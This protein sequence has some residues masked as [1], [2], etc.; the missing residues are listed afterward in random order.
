MKLTSIIH[1]LYAAFGRGD[2]PAI[3]QRLHPEVLWAANVDYT[4]PAA[5]RVPCYEAGHG[6]DFVA[7]YFGLFTRNY[8]VRDFQIAGVMEGANEAAARLLV[9]LAIRP[10]GKTVR[11]EVIHHYL[12]DD[13]GFI[14]RF[15]DIE[16][17][18]GFANAWSAE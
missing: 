6:H 1:E 7:R 10:T 3:L 8:E 5:R 13:A 14:T 9:D 12:F 2:I 11:G 17:T 18:L 4:L 16:D 15:L